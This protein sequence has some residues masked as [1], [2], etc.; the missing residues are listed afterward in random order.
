MAKIISYLT[1]DA[2]VEL[3]LTNMLE[4]DYVPTNTRWGIC[5][6]LRE[7][8]S[9]ALKEAPIDLFGPTLDLLNMVDNR[10]S[11]II[12]IYA[13]LNGLDQLYPI[14]NDGNRYHENPNKWVGEWL[15]KRRD[16][17]TKMLAFLKS[18]DIED[19]RNEL[20]AGN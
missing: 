14:E 5:G 20:P 8:G 9:A 13:D 6:N 7:L 1:T 18:N 11:S 17:M 15:A 3:F 2:V 16:L 19:L 4:P 10:V 12:K